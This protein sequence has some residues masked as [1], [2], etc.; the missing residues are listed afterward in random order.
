M[1][2]LR[3]KRSLYKLMVLKS[4]V[5][6]VGLRENN[7]LRRA[8]ARWAGRD[9]TVEPAKLLRRRAEDESPEKQRREMQGYLIQKVKSQHGSN[10]VE[11][12]ISLDQQP[13][14]RESQ[15][16]LQIA[17][18]ADSINQS[19]SS[20][21]SEKKLAEGSLAAQVLKE[22]SIVREIDESGTPARLPANRGDDSGAS[23]ER[24]ARVLQALLQAQ[25][26]NDE[27]RRLL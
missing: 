26:E 9:D 15:D 16:P 24:G 8:F 17:A 6:G 12:Y 21:K 18:L 1:R 25:K 5:E 7:W 3:F 10:R 2:R 4:C 14:F 27:K 13:E 22:L 19:D 11:E 23:D 20:N